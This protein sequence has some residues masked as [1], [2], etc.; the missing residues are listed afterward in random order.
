MFLCGRLSGVVE[1]A[2]AWLRILILC[3]RKARTMVAEISRKTQEIQQMTL[4][5]NFLCRLPS[6]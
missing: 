1:A 3:L 6:V 5:E 2:A 4:Q